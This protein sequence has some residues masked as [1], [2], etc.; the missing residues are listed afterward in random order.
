MKLL[1]TQQCNNMLEKKRTTKNKTKNVRTVYTVNGTVTSRYYG[2]FNESCIRSSYGKHAY[3][4]ISNSCH[5]QHFNQFMLLTKQR[6][7]EKSTLV[8]H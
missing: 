5:S 4:H 8:N 2:E 7:C 6:N 3:H 1:V